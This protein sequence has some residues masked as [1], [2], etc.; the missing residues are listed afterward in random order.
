MSHYPELDKHQFHI[1]VADS[2][3][4]ALHGHEFLELSYVM[5]G[6]M[7]HRVDDQTAVVQT[8]EYFIVDHGTRHAYHA[9]TE[10]PLRVVNFLFY[11]A[12]ADRTL[13]GCSTFREVVNSYLIRFSYQS[14]NASP[15]GKTLRDESGRIRV[16]LEEM[17]AEYAAKR[18]GYVEYIRCLFLEIL[19]LTMRN[20][21]KKSED[22]ATSDA[23]EQIA[24]YVKENYAGRLRLAD[25][26][27]QYNYSLSH[28]SKKFKAEMHTGF[29]DYVQ[30]IRIE[31]SCH[32]LETSALPV[33]AVAE[34]VGYGDVRFFNKTFKSVLQVTPREFRRLSGHR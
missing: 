2:S 26:A 28:L 23:V 8:G 15:T 13:A 25:L 14:L 29:S 31:Q 27:R 10:E 9:L 33:T 32:L 16:I 18:Q 34:A 24:A 30:R 17:L 1:L 11:P 21:G 7:A 5:S 19:I 3:A 22:G 6:K 4:V 12:F 20:I